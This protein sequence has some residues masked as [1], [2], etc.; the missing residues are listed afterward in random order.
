MDHLGV[1]GCLAWTH[2]PDQFRSKLS[3]KFEKGILIGCLKRNQ[4]KMWLIIRKIAII[5]RHARIY[6][7]QLPARMWTDDDGGLEKKAGTQPSPIRTIQIIPG[8][9]PPLPSLETQIKPSF[10]PD[11]FGIRSCSCYLITSD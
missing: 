7:D 8:P 1:F 3:G 2:V 10:S 6:E 4:Y 11:P 5:T 9:A